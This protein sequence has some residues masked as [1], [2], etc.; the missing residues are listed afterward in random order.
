[1]EM[2]KREMSPCRVS[3]HLSDDAVAV[4]AGGVVGAG[5]DVAGAALVADES[6]GCTGQIW[7]YQEGLSSC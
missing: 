4:N 7:G 5:D 2:R 6:E 1:M 3:C